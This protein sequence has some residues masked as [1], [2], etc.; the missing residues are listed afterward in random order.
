MTLE[1]IRVH[2]FI[3]G[4][5]NTSSFRFNLSTLCKWESHTH[6]Y[7][8]IT[9]KEKEDITEEEEY[10]INYIGENVIVDEKKGFSLC[11]K[12]CTK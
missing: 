10:N 12:N 9:I 5:I 11:L 4:G 8:L 3:N 7:I 6:H 2:T 1:K